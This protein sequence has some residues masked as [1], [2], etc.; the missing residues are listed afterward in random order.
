VLR[1]T[2]GAGFEPVWS[3]DSDRLLTVYPSTNGLT[4]PGTV[5][6]DMARF[7]PLAHNPHGIHYL[8]SGDGRHIGF[9]TGECRIGVADIDGGNTHLT[10]VLGD[11]S[12][13]VN[14][15][16]KRSCDPFSI[17][18]DGSRMAV[19]LHTGDMVDGDIGRNLSANAVIDT[20][21]G[22][23]VHLPVTGTVT[24]VFFQHDGSMLI[25]THTSSG[26]QLTLVTPDGAVSAQVSEPASTRNLELIGYA[27]A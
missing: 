4:L 10:P 6:V 18:P 12:P 24:A 15:Q 7:T 19:D 25:R 3:P 14:P 13:G 11:F 16:R 5:D 21:T 26:N 2:V 22:D 1:G 23:T 27:P 8:W 17:S 20:R 9:A